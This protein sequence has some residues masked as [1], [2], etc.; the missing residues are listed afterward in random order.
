MINR[1]N[2][3]FIIITYIFTAFFYIGTG[4]TDVYKGAGI[5]FSFYLTGFIV[6]YFIVT[7]YN[8]INRELEIYGEKGIYNTSGTKRVYRYYFSTL[9][10][11]AV[12]PVIIAVFIVPFIINILETVINFIIASLFALLLLSPEPDPEKLPEP[13]LPAEDL[14]PYIRE[15]MKT[16]N[17][18]IYY[19]IIAA[20]VLILAGVIFIFRKQIKLFFITLFSKL[21]LNNYEK[22]R[23][24]NQEI[25]TEVKKDKKY[26]LSYKDYLKKSRRITGLR[27]RFLFAY[28]YIFWSVIKKDEDL[29][30]CS[31][32]FEVAEIYIETLNPAELYQDIKYGQKSDK[33][34]GE[35]ALSD[36][37]IKSEIFL[38]DFLN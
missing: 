36:M 7:N 6:S 26:K 32:P 10:L 3:I 31:T 18:L 25:I 11:F 2:T 14:E 15:Q 21:S 28:N 30:S 4:I 13:E 37:T 38:Q 16:G 12:V 1:E 19:I 24:I 8:L 29:K 9:I 17:M 23:I 33:N 27:E 5:V 20:T 22:N 35:E 34:I